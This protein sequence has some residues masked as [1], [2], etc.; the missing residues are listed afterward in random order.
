MD[1]NELLRNLTPEL[2]FR[3]DDGP[4]RSRL[5]KTAL[6]KGDEEFAELF[7]ESTSDILVGISGATVKE[8]V[9]RFRVVSDQGEQTHKLSLLALNNEELDDCAE[10][11]SRQPTTPS[12][13]TSKIILRKRAVEGML[14]IA[15]ASRKLGCSPQF[16]KGK[17]PCTD[18]TYTEIDGKKEIK[19][20]YWSQALIDRL[21]QIK[22][23][24]IKAEELKAIADECC[25]GDR[26]WAEELLVS[27]VTPKTTAKTGGASPHGG[28]R[29]PAKNVSRDHSRPPRKKQS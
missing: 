28:T 4:F 17:I 27:L 16:L 14:D 5:I 1:M 23:N 19:E 25:D 26:A 24:G 29:Q 11:L 6:E 20:Y 13:D 7:S 18:Y 9:I 15:T 3:P 2:S 12:N 21:C 10:L 8:A 22:V